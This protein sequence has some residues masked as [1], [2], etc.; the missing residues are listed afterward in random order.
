M[1]K[2]ILVRIK[3]RYYK[4]RI[5]PPK[6]IH[7]LLQYLHHLRD[8]QAHHKAGS[9]AR[10]DL[11]ARIKTA[12]IDLMHK[13]KKNPL[14]KSPHKSAVGKNI[15][16]LMHHQGELTAKTPAMKRKQAIAI[17]LSTWRQALGKPRYKK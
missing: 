2:T 5:N 8:Q 9:A 12:R 4:V 15:R 7:E 14:L 11:S 10:K 16:Y 13:L 17:A 6:T 3:K 1:S